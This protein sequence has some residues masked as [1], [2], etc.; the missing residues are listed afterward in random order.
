MQVVK[1]EG[2][3]KNKRV[4]KLGSISIQRKER[5]IHLNFNRL[6]YLLRGGAA[7]KTDKTY[8]MALDGFDFFFP[9]LVNEKKNRRKIR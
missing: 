5:L 9:L 2:R 4:E 1:S 6:Y 8:L 3:A 7:L